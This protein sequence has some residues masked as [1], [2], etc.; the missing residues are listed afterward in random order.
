MVA[1][2][3]GPGSCG[4]SPHGGWAPFGV[5]ACAFVNNYTVPGRREEV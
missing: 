4:D 2:T 1:T 3:T 5:R